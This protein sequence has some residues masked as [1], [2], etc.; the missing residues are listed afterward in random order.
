[1]LHSEDSLSHLGEQASSSSVC[2]EDADGYSNEYAVVMGAGDA[3]RIAEL[4]T[5]LGEHFECVQHECVHGEKVV[6]HLRIPLHTLVAHAADIQLPMLLD[7]HRLRDVA[8]TGHV[9]SANGRNYD[10]EPFSMVEDAQVSRKSP[11]ANM[12]GVFGGHTAQ[13]MAPANSLSHPFGAVQRLQVITSLI[14]VKVGLNLDRIPEVLHPHTYLHI[15][16][17]IH[18]ELQ[19]NNQ[20]INY[21]FTHSLTHTHTHTGG[22]TLPST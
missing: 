13:L 8:E 11:F 19:T 9:P 16:T 4:I 12:Y 7:E 17:Y 14:R 10:V 15:Y 5:L 3:G 2:Q 20:S 18:T 6:L 21:S 1:M 22:G